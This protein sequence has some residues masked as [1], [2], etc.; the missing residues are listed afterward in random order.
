[1]K[2]HASGFQIG[3]Y[4]AGGLVA[5][6]LLGGA[7]HVLDYMRASPI[8]ESLPE[9]VADFISSIYD[10]PIDWLFEFFRSRQ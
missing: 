5:V 9:P 10:R 1:M 6:Y 3:A 7:C 8:A 4:V 2:K